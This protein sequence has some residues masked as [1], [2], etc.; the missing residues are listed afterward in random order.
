M[1]HVTALTRIYEPSNVSRT[2]YWR[3]EPWGLDS[4]P[5]LPY[6]H[7]HNLNTIKCWQA[8]ISENTRMCRKYSRRNTMCWSCGRLPTIR[9]HR[10]KHG[11]DHWTIFWTIFSGPLFHLTLFWGRGGSVI[12]YPVEILWINN[13]ST[14][15]SISWTTTPHCDHTWKIYEA[16]TRMNKNW[17]CR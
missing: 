13:E 6:K 17:Q 14:W 12:L 5:S 1:C 3:G 11:L 15:P 10:V 9:W 7:Q 2:P 16:N 4:Y 8:L